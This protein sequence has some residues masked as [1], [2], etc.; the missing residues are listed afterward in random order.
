MRPD[1]VELKIQDL[2][3][4][5]NEVINDIQLTVMMNQISDD[6]LVVA[7]NGPNKYTKSKQGETLITTHRDTH[8]DSG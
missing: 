1:K 6:R 5:I 4:Q 2:S 3:K 7:G 8:K